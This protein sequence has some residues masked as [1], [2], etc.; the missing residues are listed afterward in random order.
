MMPKGFEQY[1]RKQ[2]M[3]QHKKQNMNQKQFI[4]IATKHFFF[5]C[6]FCSRYTDFIFFHAFQWN[7][8]NNKNMLNVNKLLC[9]N[10]D[11]ALHRYTATYIHCILYRD[12]CM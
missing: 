3:Q 7:N 8:N 9:K 1:A 10:V 5:V 6:L 4:T 12:S 2:L 11:Y